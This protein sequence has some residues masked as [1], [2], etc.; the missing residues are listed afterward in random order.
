MVST[1]TSLP[2]NLII[3]SLQ[4]PKRTRAQAAAPAE[5]QQRRSKLAK[6]N[7]ISASEEAEIQEAF[8]IFAQPRSD[9]KG[10]GKADTLADM[11]LPTP[12][13]RK[14]LI[15]LGLAPSAD[16]LSEYLEILDPEQ[17]GF[18]NY[19][20]FLSVAALK[21]RSKDGEEGDEEKAQEAEEAYRL[22]TGGTEGPIGLAQLR[23]VARILR[24]DVP[25]EVLKDMILEANGGAG[26]GRGVNQEEF[27]EV[28]SRVGG[29][30]R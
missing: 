30:R 9:P 1:L 13:L 2:R 29:F 5:T 25:E 20:M 19:E 24:E 6:E 22:F 4:P 14:A 23:R 7:N 28:M 8:N 27:R 12:S 18:T 10:K 11:I 16:E 17:E 26:I 15:A 3:I 21:M